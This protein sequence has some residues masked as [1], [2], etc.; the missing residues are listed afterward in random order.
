MFAGRYQAAADLWQLGYT[1]WPTH[2]DAPKM[3]FRRA[4]CLEKMKRPAEARV[5]YEAYLT[6]YPKHL[7]SD[8]ARRRIGNLDVSD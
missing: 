3:Y 2:P 5:A 4:F 1:T 6:R 8:Q 7:W